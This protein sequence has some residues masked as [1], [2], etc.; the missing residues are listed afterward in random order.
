MTHL[1]SRLL[2]GS[3]P[4]SGVQ[5][6]M[7]LAMMLH[8]LPSR[9]QRPLTAISRELS[10]THVDEFYSARFA[11]SEKTTITNSKLFLQIW[12]TVFIWFAAR[13]GGRVTIQAVKLYSNYER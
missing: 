1:K 8:T 4:N 7:C 5:S 13:A 9:C 10:T 6:S 12:R 11:S 3:P 2:V